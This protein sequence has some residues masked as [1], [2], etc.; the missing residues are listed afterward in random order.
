MIKLSVCYFFLGLRAFFPYFFFFF[1]F[2]ELRGEVGNAAGI[3]MT[4]KEIYLSDDDFVKVFK[5]DRA[6]FP[7]P[8]SVE[9]AAAEEGRRPVVSGEKKKAVVLDKAVLFLWPF[10]KKNEERNKEMKLLYLYLSP[11]HL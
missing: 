11:C 1:F 2:A 8:A 9:A 10:E 7:G 4:S 6:A 5:K 3:I